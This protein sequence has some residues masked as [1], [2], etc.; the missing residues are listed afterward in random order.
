[1]IAGSGSRITR[2][3][4]LVFVRPNVARAYNH[5]L[6]WDNSSGKQEPIMP[7]SALVLTLLVLFAAA[8]RPQELSPPTTDEPQ[9]VNPLVPRAD[10]DGV[11]FPGPGIVSP[12]VL[13]R[14]SV[15]YPA[16]EPDS[17]IEGSTVLRLVI[18]VDGA[19]ANIEVAFSH[20]EAFDRAA[21]DAVQQSKFQAGTLSGNPVPVHIFA[22]IR[23]YSDGRE[24]YPRIS[25]H[26]GPGPAAVSSRSY[27]TPPVAL[28]VAAAEYSQQARKAKLQGTVLLSLTV[29]EEGM[30]TDIKVVKS[31]G[32]GLDESAVRCASEYRFRPATKDGA[33]VAAHITLEVNFRLY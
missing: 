5:S 27:D 4:D 10:K 8:V 11:Y 3:P 13:E 16:G 26:F 1:L 20:G 28:H 17:A 31:L 29:T 30:P 7:K 12:I 2:L 6:K 24:T 18:G 22:R 14:A 23:F 9:N 15:V 33:P 19:P 25:G 32:M 21:I